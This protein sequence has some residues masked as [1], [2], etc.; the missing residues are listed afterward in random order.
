MKGDE[1]ASSLVGI[2]K[3]LD[4]SAFYSDGELSTTDNRE[5]CWEKERYLTY[6]PLDDQENR[7]PNVDSGGMGYSPGDPASEKPG[8]HKVSMNVRSVYFRLP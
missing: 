2:T 3:Q 6:E 4:F 5:S 8:P 7:A 1:L